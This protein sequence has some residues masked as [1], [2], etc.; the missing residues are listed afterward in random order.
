[1]HN[2]LPQGS[3]LAKAFSETALR[4][5]IWMLG[6][7]N[8][9]MAVTVIQQKAAPCNINILQ[10]VATYFHWAASPEYHYQLGLLAQACCNSLYRYVSGNVG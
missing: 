1:M 2:Q 5:W 7:L 6:W 8:R 3:I 4:N 10:K 9:N